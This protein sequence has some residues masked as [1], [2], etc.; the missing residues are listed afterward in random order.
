MYTYFSH[1][2]S[3]SHCVCMS[4]APPIPLEAAVEALRG[5]DSGLDYLLDSIWETN[6]T[7][8]A[9]KIENGIKTTSSLL[10]KMLDDMPANEEDQRAFA[11]SYLDGESPDGGTVNRILVLIFLLLKRQQYAIHTYQIHDRSKR[12]HQ[13]SRY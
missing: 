2:S 7:Q 8:F 11:S 1:S 13:L 3:L 5:L 9:N 4:Q 6:E 10:Y 12:C